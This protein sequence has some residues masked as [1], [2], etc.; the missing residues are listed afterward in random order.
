MVGS[1]KKQYEEWKAENTEWFKETKAKLANEKSANLG[2]LKTFS[3]E[4][5]TTTFGLP[6]DQYKKLVAENTKFLQAAKKENLESFCGPEKGLTD[7]EKIENDLAVKILIKSWTNDGNVK[8]WGASSAVSSPV[9]TEPKVSS[10]VISNSDNKETDTTDIVSEITVVTEPV[11]DKEVLSPS[12]NADN[13]KEEVKLVETEDESDRKDELDSE[14]ESYR[15]GEL[16]GEDTT[17]FSDEI[18]SN[19]D[20]P[21]FIKVETTDS[22]KGFYSSANSSNSLT[23]SLE[24]VELKVTDNN[25]LSSYNKF[26]SFCHSIADRLSL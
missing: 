19:I 7:I 18:S 25:S 12:E 3:T 21:K 8:C 24:P 13:T 10:D 22:L 23:S 17:Y 1:S 16:G 6:N 11:S 5:S 15:E 9:T 20:I 14:D 4:T 26:S 2:S